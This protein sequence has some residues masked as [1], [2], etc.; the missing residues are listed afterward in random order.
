MPVHVTPAPG[1][2]RVRPPMPFVLQGLDA[3]K[4]DVTLHAPLPKRHV[5]RGQ[6]GLSAVAIVGN[7][8]T[9]AMACDSR[10]VPI[11]L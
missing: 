3:R 9:T 11:K 4:P 5:W 2:T 1:V 10:M 6:P 8:T 7:L